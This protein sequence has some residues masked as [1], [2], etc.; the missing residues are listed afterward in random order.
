VSVSA[1]WIALELRHD[2]VYNTICQHLFNATPTHSQ[3][4]HE[5]DSSNHPQSKRKNT[6]IHDSSN[7]TSTYSHNLAILGGDATLIINQRFASE[8]VSAIFINHP[9][10]PEKILET[11]A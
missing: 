2:R 7:A 1:Y 10:P 6:P 4:G 3:A 5:I 9:Q 8:T 11:K